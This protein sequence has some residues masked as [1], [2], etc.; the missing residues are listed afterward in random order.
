MEVPL[1]D[2]LIPAVID[3][4]G[5]GDDE[6]AFPA[7]DEESSESEPDDDSESELEE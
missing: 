2:I 6:G 4:M 7:S 1:Y 5:A 3:G